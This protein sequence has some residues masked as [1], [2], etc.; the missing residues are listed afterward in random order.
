MIF[1][2]VLSVVYRSWFCAPISPGYDRE[3]YNCCVVGRI[4]L[5]RNAACDVVSVDF[6][7]SAVVT[8]VVMFFVYRVCA[9]AKIVPV[10]PGVL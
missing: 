4:S 9:V 10:V 5:F 7:K 1:E 2:T 6:D 8:C 3:C